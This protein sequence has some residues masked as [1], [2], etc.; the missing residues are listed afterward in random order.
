MLG[1][2]PDR[3]F[4]GH[5]ITIIKS[6]QVYRT[7][8]AP[9]SAFAT[10]VE[11]DVEITHGELAQSAIDRFAISAAGEIRFC[12]R[13]PM[14]AHFE[15]CDDVICILLRFQIEDQWWKPE[16]TQRTCSENPS[17]ETRRHSIVQN[18]FRRARRVAE[19]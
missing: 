17:L 4:C 1:D 6:C 13:T 16:N 18:F 9:Q 12:H 5:P 14:S 7:R 11:V 3:F 19:V 2:E 15:N 10:Q 8:V